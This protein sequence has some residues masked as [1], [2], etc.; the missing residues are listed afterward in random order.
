M[1]SS[2]LCLPL[3]LLLLP[4]DRQVQPHQRHLDA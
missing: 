3:L 2:L 1:T 4:G